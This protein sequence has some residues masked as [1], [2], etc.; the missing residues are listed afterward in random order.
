M[1][2]LIAL[3]EVVQAVEVQSLPYA[4]EYSAQHFKLQ[5]LGVEPII[6]CGR[7]SG[8]GGACRRA[9]GCCGTAGTRR[10][11]GLLRRSLTLASGVIGT[12]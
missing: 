4:V 11:G 9:G 12:L 3:P 7:G 5:V 6:R 1:V 2:Q 10:G 8:R